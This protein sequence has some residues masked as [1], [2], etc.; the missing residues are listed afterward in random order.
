LSGGKTSEADY[1][2]GLRIILYPFLRIYDLGGDDPMSITRRKFLECRKKTWID[3]EEEIINFLH[4]HRFIAYTME[5]IASE[6]KYNLKDYGSLGSE[7]NVRKCLN[8]LLREHRIQKCV[9]EGENY[10]IIHESLLT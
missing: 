8:V 1:K 4:N 10:Y 3:T 5:E 7:K 2:K 9:S 6:L